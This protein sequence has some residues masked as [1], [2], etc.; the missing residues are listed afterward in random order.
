M[1]RGTKIGLGIGCGALLVVGAVVIVGGY[2][3]LN[4][5]EKTV[6]EATQE[7]EAEGR[8]F[9]KTTDQEGCIKDGMRRSRSVG[10]VD[11]GGALALTAFVD[12]CLNTSRPTEGFCNGVPSFWSMKE[13]EWGADLCRKAGIDPEKTAC[14]HVTKRKH[15]FCTMPK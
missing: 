8:E 1:K 4:Y 6:G 9:G 14:I 2:F 10:F 15:Q 3:A 7:S 12:A 11:F 13:G 5:L